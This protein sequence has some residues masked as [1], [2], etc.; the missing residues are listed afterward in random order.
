MDGVWKNAHIAEIDYD[1][2]VA[3]SAIQYLIVQYSTVQYTDLAA[4]PDQP[5][6]AAGGGVGVLRPGPLGGAALP[7]LAGGLQ[8]WT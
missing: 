1:T 3:R 4:G 2:F 6:P 5:L 7:D 8:T